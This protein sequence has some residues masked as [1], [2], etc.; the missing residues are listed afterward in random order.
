[1]NVSPW[2][3]Y[4]LLTLVLIVA[5]GM[6]GCESATVTSGPTPTKC[7]LAVVGPAGIV[8]D[9]GTATISV[10]APQE[11]G[12]NVSTQAT[13]ISDVLPLSGQG[14]GMVAFR[15]APN[16]AP[17]V[18]QSDIVINEEQVR[19]SQDAAPCLVTITPTDLTIVAA[20]GTG[21]INVS[22]LTGCS[23]TAASDVPWITITSAVTGSGNGS[24]RFSVASNIGMSRSGN[25][26]IADRS[27]TVTQSGAQAPPCSYFISP[28]SQTIGPGGGAGPLVSVAAA[29]GCTWTAVSN[30][31]WITVGSGAIRNGNGSVTFTVAANP[32]N[33]RNGTLTIGGQTFTVMQGTSCTYQLNGSMVNAPPAG[34][35]LQVLVT[36]SAPLCS[37]TASTT[38]SWITIILGASST[39]SGQARFVV[40]ANTG[41]FRS[42]TMVIAGYTVT[43]MQ[44]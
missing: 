43:V 29:S 37:W 5:A 7:Q 23:W 12:W 9:G 3:P 2:S 41:G 6:V 16:P 19:I 25:V 42:A 15:A 34:G 39:G 38:A 10:S 24:I 33:P 35:T 18:R 20:G 36:A 22:T 4:V 40:P 13:W 21:T 32:G 27:A 44:P 17:A 31:P 28:T 26:T 30:N 8:A 11:C 14:N 1:M